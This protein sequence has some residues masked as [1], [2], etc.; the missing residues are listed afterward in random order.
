LL[1]EELEEQEVFALGLD[2]EVMLAI[3]SSHYI[4]M[5]NQD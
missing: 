1:P 3:A 5:K 2:D 4:Y